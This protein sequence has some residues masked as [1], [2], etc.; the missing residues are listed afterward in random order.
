M[1]GHIMAHGE[2]LNRDSERVLA[3]F[4][5]FIFACYGLFGLSCMFW[6]V[7]ARFG[8]LWLA[9]ASCCL[10]LLVLACFG[11]FWQVFAHH[12]MSWHVLVRFV[13]VLAPF[14]QFDLYGPFWPA[15]R[16]FMDNIRK[17]F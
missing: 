17:K 1:F 3:R 4:N 14:R 6:H 11:L 7:M 9:V 5:Q 8:Q 15:L 13:P 12:G 16:C 2:R 10:L